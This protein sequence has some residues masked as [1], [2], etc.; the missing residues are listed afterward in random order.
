MLDTGR[1]RSCIQCDKT[2]KVSRS[3]Q[4]YCSNKCRIRHHREEADYCFFCGQPH[5]EDKHHLD[6]IASR[7]TGRYSGQETV[8]CCKSCNGAIGSVSWEDIDAQFSHLIDHYTAK[9]GPEKPEWDED[10][11][12]ELGASLRRRI[13]KLLAEY[14]QMNERIVY[15]KVRRGQIFNRQS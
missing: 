8:P 11:I 2:F 6:P 1:E 9:R 12:K 5:P 14:Q 13:K 10:E 7:A 3:W 15:L 4:L